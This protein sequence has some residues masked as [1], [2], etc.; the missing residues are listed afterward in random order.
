MNL[1]LDEEA[2]NYII[3]KTLTDLC[4]KRAAALRHPG[5]STRH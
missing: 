1:S 4:E 2:A 3:I 5:Y